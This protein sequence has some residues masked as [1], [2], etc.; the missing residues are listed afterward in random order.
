MR[1]VTAVLSSILLIS[2]S[3]C[4]G[5]VSASAHADVVEY[6]PGRWCR[7]GKRTTVFNA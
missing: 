6:H 1:T 4:G 7:S 2:L 5:A 3:V